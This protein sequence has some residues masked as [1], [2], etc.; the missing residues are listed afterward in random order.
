MV[1]GKPLSEAMRRLLRSALGKSGGDFGVEPVAGLGRWFSSL[2]LSRPFRS[3]TELA[4]N[5]PVCR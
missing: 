1:A 4:S 5:D 3:E 2:H